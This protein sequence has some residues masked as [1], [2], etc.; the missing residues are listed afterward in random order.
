MTKGNWWETTSLN[1]MN[2]EQWES[3]CDRCGICCLHKL[4]DEDTNEVVCTNVV[5]KF[6]D[7]KK[8]KCSDYK[9]RKQNQPDCLTITYELLDKAQHWLPKTCAYRRLYQGN[10]LPSW[11]P[12]ITNKNK[13]VN[14][15][16]R[17]Y[18]ELENKHNIDNL[19]DYIVDINI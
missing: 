12:L 8:S 18:A 14:V 4:Q 16:I 19:E 9:N 17:K 1:E 2:H 11:H 5:C 15:S 7:L 10:K 3:L 6:F 13:P